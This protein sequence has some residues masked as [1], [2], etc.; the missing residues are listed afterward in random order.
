M[1][2][3]IYIYIHLHIFE[4][5]YRY[6]CMAITICIF[7]YIPIYNNPA[8]FVLQVRKLETSVLKLIYMH[9]Q[10]YIDKCLCV[11]MYICMYICMCIYIYLYIDIDMY[12]CKYKPGPY[13]PT[14]SW[15]RGVGAQAAG[16]H[17]A[18]QNLRGA[19][20]GPDRKVRILVCV[21]HGRL[22]PYTRTVTGDEHAAG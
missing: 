14:G 22:W 12:T 4:D 19:G 10:I 20:A 21:A 2:I 18:D 11:Y 1:Y 16:L 7:I 15:A 3:C 6:I 9:T 8:H 17:H 13:W 5:D